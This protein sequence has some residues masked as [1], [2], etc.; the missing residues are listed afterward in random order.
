MS[1]KYIHIAKRIIEQIEREHILTGAKMPSLRQF[2]ELH[3]ISM[4]T[5]LACYRY[6]EKFDYLSAEY[7]KGYYVQRP[8]VVPQPIRRQTFPLFKT[9]VCNTDKRPDQRPITESDYSLATAQL[10]ATLIDRASLA[11]CLKAVTKD[12][13]FTLL[14]DEINGSLALRTQLSQH[15]AT[16]GFT[17]TE[18]ELVI[19]NGCLD[20]VLI[21]LESVSQTGDVIAVSS[22]CYSGLLDILATLGRAVI[23]IPSTET[24]MDLVQLES[25][26]ITQKVKACLFTA[27]HQNPTG[28]SLGNEQKQAIAELA[29]KYQVPI[30]EDDVFRELSHQRTIPLPIKYYDQ[31][32]WVIWCSS[33]SKTLAPGLRIGWSVAGK[34]T[35]KFIRQRQARTLGVNQPIQLALARYISKGYYA[36]HINKVNRALRTNSDQYIAFL[37]AHLPT[38]ADVYAPSGGLVLW[39][40]LPEVDTQALADE[41]SE[42]GVYVKAGAQFSSTRLYNDCLRINM[43]NLASCE[44]YAQLKLLCKL[45]RK[46]MNT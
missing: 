24:G 22:P 4:T 5:A 13:D 12:A 18:E 3:N 39:L 27:N 20:A 21:A 45:A 46:R 40:T 25:A 7:K 33:V 10:D 42:K 26:L 29:S 34:F 11:R 37:H 15:F 8:F 30:I 17:V 31:Q 36:T 9:K 32:G 14:Y 6:L 43:G 19:T 2:C 28:H 44:I 1:A 16:Q 38:H 41:L 35:D 23:E